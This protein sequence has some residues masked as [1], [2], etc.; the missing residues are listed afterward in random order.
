VLIQERDRLVRAPREFR[1]VTKRAPSDAERADLLFGWRVLPHVRSNGILLARG[2]AVVGVGAGQPSRVDSVAIACR[3]AGERARGAAL[4][5]DAFF[6][7]P[8][9]IEEAAAA[10]ITAVIQPGGSVRDDATIAAADRAGIAML[11]TGER[12]FRH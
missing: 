4:A 1:V 8:D 12:H 5:S 2:G 6:P 7:F 3:K 9:G 10:G 11:V